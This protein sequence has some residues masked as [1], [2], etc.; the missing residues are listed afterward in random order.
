MLSK[1]IRIASFVAILFACFIQSQTIFAESTTR[2]HDGPTASFE[3]F[4]YQGH[5]RVFEAKSSDKTYRN[6]VL[7][8]FYPDPSVVR[9]G[10]DFYMVN[11]TFG[12]YPGLPVFHSRDL[13]NW[14]Q[15]GNVIDRTDMMSFDGIHLSQQGLYAPTI[16][17]HDGLF[18]V[19]NTCVACG[20][21]FL[22]TAKNPAGPWSDPIWLPDVG[23]IDPSLLFDGDRVFIVNHN[24]PEGPEL[25]DGHRAIWIRELDPTTFQSISERKMLIDGGVTIKEEPVYIEGPHLYKVR[26]KY[27][28]SAAEGGTEMDH[29]QVIFRSDNIWGP[30]IPFENNPILTQRNLPENRPNP[31]TSTGHADLVTDTQGNWWAVFLGTRTYDRIHFNTGRETFL[32]PVDWRS[33]W[34][35]ILEP[36]KTVPYVLM[37][38]KPAD[39]TV[40][41]KPVTGNFTIREEFDAELPGDWV[42]VRTP[43]SDWWKSGGGQL[44]IKPGNERIGDVL[45]PSIV[46]RRLQHMNMQA[47]TAMRFNPGSIA[48]EAGMV[49]LQND[50]YY[51]AMGLGQNRQGQTVLRLRHRDGMEGHIHGK[52]LKETPIDIDPGSL[53]YLRVDVRGPVIDFSWSMDNKHYDSLYAGANARTLSTMR[54][55]GFTGAM[56]GMYA[57]TDQ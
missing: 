12:Y 32:L 52:I 49:A 19:A 27:Y 8:G 4:E 11:S 51:F 10:N 35:V 23:G 48:D 26:G 43:R 45:Q 42:F 28:L 30:Y 6:P 1:P 37:R 36:G 55:G 9:V 31:I 46:A 38:P 24:T 53:I 13:V 40:L 57:E 16:E 25:Y 39:A 17:Y 20:G 33:G 54:A 2:E 47:I 22:V 44:T 18:Y 15:I 34:P 7:A 5:D 50:A 3:W 41:E 29:R 21:N 56:I 14:T